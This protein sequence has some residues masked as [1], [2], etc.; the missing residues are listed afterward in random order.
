MGEKRPA[1]A[2][3][4]PSSTSSSSSSLTF[5]PHGTALHCTYTANGNATQRDLGLLFLLLLLL[6]TQPLDQPSHTGADETAGKPRSHIGRP[7]IP[8][9]PAQGA[10]DW[11]GTKGTCREISGP[12]P[13]QTQST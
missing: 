7:I 11:T 3:P 10:A 9:F 12:R 6:L 13:T 5:S 8:R 1:E 2:K 4:Q